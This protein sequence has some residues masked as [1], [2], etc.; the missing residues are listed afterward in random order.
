MKACIGALLPEYGKGHCSVK[1]RSSSL[2]KFGVM[3]ASTALQRHC[4]QSI[5]P[6]QGVLNG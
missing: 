2:L 1:L 3:I 5:K 4:S 6:Y